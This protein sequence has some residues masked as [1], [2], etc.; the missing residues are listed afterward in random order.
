MTTFTPNWSWK[1]IKVSVK[2]KTSTTKNVDTLLRI[3]Y[4]EVIYRGKPHKNDKCAFWIVWYFQMLDP[5]MWRMLRLKKMTGE[6]TFNQESDEF[7]V[8]KWKDQGNRFARTYCNISKSSC[9]SET[10]HV[11]VW[12]AL[13]WLFTRNKYCLVLRFILVNSATAAAYH[14]TTEGYFFSD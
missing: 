4:K 5:V 3:Y 13:R 14:L 10:M 6:E 8:E 12:K 9:A 11:H 1:R 7:M 2:K